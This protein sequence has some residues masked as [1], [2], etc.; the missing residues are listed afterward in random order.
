[1]SN[2]TTYV[3]TN[4]PLAKD[5]LISLKE[6]KNDEKDRIL[7]LKS[8]PVCWR[9]PETTWLSSL[10]NRRQT[11]MKRIISSLY[12][13]IIKMNPCRT[14]LIFIILM[15]EIIQRVSSIPDSKFIVSLTPS[16]ISHL[17]FSIASFIHFSL[18]FFP[19]SQ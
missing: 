17:L 13:L 9:Y 1:M 3:K 8:R 19:I 10:E 15:T 11:P 16:R 18:S 2:K 5:K 14:Q 12:R 4:F 6:E 7:S